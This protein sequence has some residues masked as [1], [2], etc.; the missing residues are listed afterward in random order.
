MA[1]FGMR[2]MEVIEPW[3][4]RRFNTEDK[5]KKHVKVLFSSVGLKNQ[6]PVF[7]ISEMAPKL[8]DVVG[9]GFGVFVLVFDGQ[10]E[11]M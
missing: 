3:V 10:R 2:D 1:P 4:L 5:H 6:H 8:N 9:L 7:K 11:F